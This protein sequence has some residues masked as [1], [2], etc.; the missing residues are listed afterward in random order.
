MHAAGLS[1]VYTDEVIFRCVIN[2]VAVYSAVILA[3]CKIVSR[4]RRFTHAYTY[5]DYPFLK[6]GSTYDS[7]YCNYCILYM[8]FICNATYSLNVSAQCKYET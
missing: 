1:T 5:A 8:H 2:A 6:K 4:P 3:A 7:R